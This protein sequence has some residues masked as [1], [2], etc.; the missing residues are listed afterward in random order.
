MIRL[1][2]LLL[3]AAFAAALLAQPAR[4]LNAPKFATLDG[5]L[6]LFVE[7]E[8]G[9][10]ISLEFVD[11]VPQSQF[12]GDGI[13]LSE[14]LFLEID[15][16]SLEK[17]E[18]K[19][20]PLRAA[21]R[22]EALSDE[23]FLEKI[24]GGTFVKTDGSEL[25]TFDAASPC[26]GVQGRFEP[27]K[28]ADWA[29]YD[30]AEIAQV[31]RQ[32]AFRLLE[33]KG[34]KWELDA[35]QA[36]SL[37]VFRLN[38]RYPFALLFN[39]NGNSAGYILATDKGLEMGTDD[40]EGADCGWLFEKNA[41]PK[42]LDWAPK[43]NWRTED[44]YTFFEKNGLKGLR[45]TVTGIEVLPAVYKEIELQHSHIVGKWGEQRCHLFDALAHPLFC[46]KVKDQTQL[47]ALNTQGQGVQM[48]LNDKVFWLMPNGKL[49]RNPVFEKIVIGVCGTV[50]HYQ[51][52]IFQ[53][54]W[55]GWKIQFSKFGGD[56]ST[57][58]DT[59]VLDYL[60]IFRRRY[61]DLCF[62]NGRRQQ[63]DDETGGFGSLYARIPA[64]YCIAT[65]PD[66]Q[67]DLVELSKTDQHLNGKV[68]LEN[69]EY[70][71]K[72]GNYQPLFFKKAGL[73]GFF[74]AMTEGRFAT[75]DAFDHAFAR[76]EMP[77]GKKGWVD[78]NGHVFL[79]G[80]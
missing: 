76:I 72:T 64:G 55:G 1:S 13:R 36:F 71:A 11:A 52:T 44:R 18:L 34:R 22:L 33:K 80:E 7:D 59:Y 25:L 29:A 46:P 4:T 66:G 12:E 74:P 63:M 45:D 31:E 47:R 20:Y 42:Y 56:G 79:D 19:D 30:S 8:A 24:Q 3:F 9:E 54:S 10:P 67:F 21:R 48:L 68:T 6:L 27:F 60:E 50:T 62:L 58:I 14:A 38:D 75:L 16:V 32:I 41:R 57:H 5:A 78:L 28:P 73:W 61:T 2:L 53:E 39:E 40:C 65:R 35:S 17:E 15:S 26:V 37:A 51:D 77:G 43:E 70:I 49:E 69:A 23:A